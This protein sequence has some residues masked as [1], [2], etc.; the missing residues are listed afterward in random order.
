MK[1]C[2]ELVTPFETP[3]GRDAARVAVL[4]SLLSMCPS[5]ERVEQIAAAWGIPV[6]PESTRMT[7][8][9]GE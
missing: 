2:T 8:R 7:L 3:S 9:G 4:E 6:P 1:T 5:P